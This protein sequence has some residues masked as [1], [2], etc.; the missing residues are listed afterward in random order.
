MSKSTKLSI[1][2]DDI[3]WK[4]IESR[5]K[6]IQKDAV[7]VAF[8]KPRPNGALTA[9]IRFGIEVVREMR[10]KDRAKLS[11]YINPDNIFQWMV[12]EEPNGYM[13]RKTTHS[14]DLYE[15]T[16]T[17]KDLSPGFTRQKTVE[18]EVSGKQIIFT[19]PTE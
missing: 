4:I 17:W 19:V 18:H 12:T 16:L 6:S 8:S 3:R 14:A 9:N 15:I 11:V 10:W 2:Q 1:V 13:L 7:M 5:I